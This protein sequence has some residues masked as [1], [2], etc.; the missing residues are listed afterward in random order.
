MVWQ[1]VAAY[2]DGFSGLNGI[3]NSQVDG[4]GA[5]ATGGRVEIMGDCLR[6]IIGLAIPYKFAAY[7]GV[8]GLTE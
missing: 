7:G 3:K 8:Y 2:C 5:V 4:D 1:F 6:S